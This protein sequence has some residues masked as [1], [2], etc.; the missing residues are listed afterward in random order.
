MGRLGQAGKW[1]RVSARWLNRTRRPGVIVLMYHRVG[2]QTSEEIDVST[3]QFKYQVAYLLRRYRIIS[4]DDAVSD[5]PSTTNDA[6]DR[7]VLTFDDG[8]KETYDALLPLLE[9]Y[10]VPVTLYL[11]TLYIET[12]RPMDWGQFRGWPAARRPLPMTWDQIRTL[13]LTGL[14][15]IGSHT[16]SHADL[17]QL[18]GPDIRRELHDSRML[19][20]DRLGITVRHFAYPF[21]SISPLA[22]EIVPGYYRTAVVGGSK[23]NPAS[24]PAPHA[25]CRMPVSRS[26]GPWLFRMRLSALPTTRTV[27]TIQPQGG[28]R[29]DRSSV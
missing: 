10:R 9:Q 11:P 13:S 15:T 4:L 27:G 24:L 28:R 19:I 7:V 17:A 12:G 23:K 22:S 14:V 2:G 6:V 21:G 5:L 1:I 26:D 16:H 8:Y 29:L 3:K 25:M 18:G 20:E